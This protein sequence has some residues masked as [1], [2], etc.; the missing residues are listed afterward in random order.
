MNFDEHNV[1]SVPHQMPVRVWSCKSFDEYAVN[2]AG[3]DYERFDTMADAVEIFGE[4]YVPEELA[5]LLKSGQV[6]A[7]H[8]DSLD[9]WYIPAAKF[10]AEEMA[11]DYLASDDH[12]MIVMDTLEEAKAIAEKYHGHKEIEVRAAARKLVEKYED[13]D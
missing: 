12:A 1:I 4:G 9:D 3:W 5:E 11:R 6:I 2:H 10:N 8:R 7:I 13:K